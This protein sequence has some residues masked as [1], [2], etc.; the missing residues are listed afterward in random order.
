MVNAIRPPV[1]GKA[2]LMQLIA[3][4]TT[5][6]IENSDFHSHTEARFQTVI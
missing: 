6:G 5:K 1:K 3:D 4:L 2:G